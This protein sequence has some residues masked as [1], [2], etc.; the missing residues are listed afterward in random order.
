[1]AISPLAHVTPFGAFRPLSQQVD[2]NDRPWPRLTLPQRRGKR[3]I[4]T[5]ASELGGTPLCQVGC[6]SVHD[7]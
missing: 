4:R 7:L 5:D 6:E 3:R 2:S 1:M